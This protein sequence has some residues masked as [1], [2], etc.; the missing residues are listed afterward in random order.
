MSAIEYISI[1]HVQLFDCVSTIDEVE[2]KLKE[3]DFPN[4]YLFDCIFLIKQ[5]SSKYFK[6]KD[7]LISNFNNNISDH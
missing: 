7:M 6:I 3:L 1:F 5:E 2:E 4:R